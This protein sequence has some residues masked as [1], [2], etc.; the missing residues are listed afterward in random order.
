MVQA[1]FFGSVQGYEELLLSNE[2]IDVWNDGHNFESLYKFID[3]CG[4]G[5]CL[6]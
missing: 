1:L 6:G 3:T 2:E 5:N 4:N